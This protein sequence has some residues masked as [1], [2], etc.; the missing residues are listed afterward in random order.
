MK[1]VGQL[2]ERRRPF[3]HEAHGVWNGSSRRE[4]V[5]VID[6]DDAGL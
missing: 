2:E 3:I 1:S 6:G 4:R 5:D